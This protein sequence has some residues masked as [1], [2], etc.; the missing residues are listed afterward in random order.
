M[1]TWSWLNSS[2]SFVRHANGKHHS[3]PMYP[4]TLTFMVEYF[5]VNAK[6]TGSFWK[7]LL[8]S[9]SMP[10]WLLTI[11]FLSPFLS[12]ALSLKTRWKC[13]HSLLG[14]ALEHDSMSHGGSR[15]S[16]LGG[17]TCK[18]RPPLSPHSW[19]PR[20]Y[21]RKEEGRHSQLHVKVSCCGPSGWTHQTMIKTTSCTAHSCWGC[22]AWEDIQYT[23]AF[24]W[25]TGKEW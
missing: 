3:D 5:C 12:S 14:S 1:H 8:N 24:L 4:V 6:T 18:W 15:G 23:A 22:H 19:P 21:L 13:R 20:H 7:C 17:S 9:A 11:Y 25:Y 16:R 2:I 10:R